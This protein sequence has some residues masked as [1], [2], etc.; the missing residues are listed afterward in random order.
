MAKETVIVTG[1]AGYIGSHTIIELLGRDDLEVV[2]IDNFSRSDPSSYARIGQISGRNIQ[3]YEF[4]LCD[5]DMLKKSLSQVRNIAGII[6][7]AAYKSVPESVA[8]PLLYYKNN[9]TSLVNLLEFCSA[10]K[11]KNFIFSSSCSV[12]GN[13]D[14]LPVTES[15]P[16]KEAISPYGHT[17]QISEDLLKFYCKA[18]RDFNVVALRYFNPVGAHMSGKHGELPLVRPDNLVPIITQTASGKNSLTVF[19]NKFDTRDGYCIRDYVHVSD[20]AEAHLLA[21]DFLKKGKNKSNYSLFNLGTGNGVSV[22]EA[23][24]SFEKMSGITLRYKIG[25]PRPGDVVAVYADNSLAEKELG[26]SPRYTLDDMMLSAWK[27]QQ[28]LDH[29]EKA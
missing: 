14:E 1:G 16:V 7:F 9:I 23:I 6:H 27:W 22:L 2:S 26:W 3:V 15:T 13:A 12:Y 25:D 5:A 8:D 17:K 18:N 20:I 21:L 19:G 29:A 4:D 10:N 24:K 11:V 28:T